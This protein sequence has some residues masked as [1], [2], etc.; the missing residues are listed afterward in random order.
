MAVYHA[1]FG[2]KGNQ[3]RNG[4]HISSSGM[5]VQICSISFVSNLMDSNDPVS[6]CHKFVSL[7][8]EDGRLK[9][10]HIIIGKQSLAETCAN[11]P[12][13]VAPLLI[14]YSNIERDAKG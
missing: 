10:L 13:H 12:R 5:K 14:T 6:H 11:I 2:P 8:V 9:I 7:R 1:R 4:Q 3:F